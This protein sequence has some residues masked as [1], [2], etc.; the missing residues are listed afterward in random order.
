MVHVHVY[1]WI[2][3]VC[4]GLRYSFGSPRL[5]LRRRTFC[6]RRSMKLVCMNSA[7]MN[8]H[9]YMYMYMYNSY[10]P[11][12]CHNN[13]IQHTCSYSVWPQ[14]HDVYMYVTCTRTCIW[15]TVLLQASG[16]CFN[17]SN[18]I[19][20]HQKSSSQINPLPQRQS[21]LPSGRCTL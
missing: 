14:M 9:T 10:S 15:Y 21:S 18:C 6:R 17:C 11:M 4:P 3:L 1:T 2:F 5:C 16:P 19:I 7:H 12:Y 20:I 8:P 13:H